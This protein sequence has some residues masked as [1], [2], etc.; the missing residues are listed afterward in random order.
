MKKLPHPSTFYTACGKKLPH[1]S[2]RLADAAV[3][4]MFFCRTHL[5]SAA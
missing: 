5:F 2:Q 4:S 1:S 3:L